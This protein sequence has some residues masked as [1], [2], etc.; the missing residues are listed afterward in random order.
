MFPCFVCDLYPLEQVQTKQKTKSTRY[1]RRS[2]KKLF[3]VRAPTK[4]ATNP[5][6][7]APIGAQLRQNTFR[8]I[9]SFCFFLMPKK[10]WKCFFRKCFSDLFSAFHYIQQILKD[11]GLIRCQNQIPRG[12]WFRHLG[13]TSWNQDLL[14]S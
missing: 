10:I 13:Q 2:I 1:D 3:S 12:I 9:Y 4:A 11:L 5:A 7:M 14:L 8:T 6:S